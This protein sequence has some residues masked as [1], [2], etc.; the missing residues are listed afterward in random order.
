MC[1]CAS[2][3]VAAAAL[4]RKLPAGQLYVGMHVR[5]MASD[6][7][8]LANWSAALRE[9]PADTAQTLRLLAWDTGVNVSEYTAVLRAL[10]RVGRPPLYIASDSRVVVR[11][12]AEQCPSGQVL[13]AGSR[14]LAHTP[15]TLDAPLLDWL[16]LSEAGSG[17]GRWGHDSSFQTSAVV[18][19]RFCSA[20]MVG[21]LPKPW[22]RRRRTHAFTLWNMLRRATICYDIDPSTCTRGRQR[23]ATQLVEA[24]FPDTPCSGLTTVLECV[25]LLH[26]GMLSTRFASS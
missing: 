5:T 3:L 2:I 4:Q 10:C 11:A 21:L 6:L 26:A 16:A 15:E 13:S 7:R 24:G 18:R 19:G 8:P 25:R 9:N 23:A 17:C 12:L 20:K 22:G 1:V 14:P